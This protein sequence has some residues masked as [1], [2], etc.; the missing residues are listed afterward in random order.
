[1]L[2]A[3]LPTRIDRYL[4]RRIAD[5]PDAALDRLLADVAPPTLVGRIAN[6]M[7]EQREREEWDVGNTCDQFE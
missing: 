6:E 2:L 3:A 5:A 1:M 4:T 7:A